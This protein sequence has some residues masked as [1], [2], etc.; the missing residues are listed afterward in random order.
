MQEKEAQAREERMEKLAK[1]HGLFKDAGNKSDTQIKKE[2][3]QALEDDMMQ[4]PLFKS[5]VA[6]SNAAS[7]TKLS[8]T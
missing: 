5:F 4:M 2:A 7:P 6:R 8:M 1:Q 3:E